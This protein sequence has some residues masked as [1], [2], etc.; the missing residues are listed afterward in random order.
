MVMLTSSVP[1]CL[2]C[3]HIDYLQVLVGSSSII[4]AMKHR[5][6]VIQVSAD[7]F[8]AIQMAIQ[9]CSLGQC[10]LSLS[11]AML[12]GNWIRQQES[13]DFA[14]QAFAIAT[15]ITAIIV[16]VIEGF[17]LYLDNARAVLI[18]DVRV[19]AQMQHEVD[20]IIAESVSSIAQNTADQI[21]QDLV[22]EGEITGNKQSCCYQA[23]T[24]VAAAIAVVVVILI[25]KMMFALVSAVTEWVTTIAITAAISHPGS[26]L[27]SCLHKLQALYIWHLITPSNQI[28][29]LMNCSQYCL[30]Q[31]HKYQ[32]VNQCSRSLC[33][34]QGSVF[35]ELSFVYVGFK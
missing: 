14:L 7:S 29:M 24:I 4:I 11:I 31:C 34:G 12:K 21:C 15:I 9:E 6:V 32:S 18:A 10:C 30:S 8:Q 1:R 27:C 3:Q 26:I 23:A 20:R 25:A 13:T 22:E 17:D 2:S 33:C 19:T 35:P 28:L 16:S 5:F